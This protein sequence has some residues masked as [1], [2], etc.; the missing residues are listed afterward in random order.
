[1]T[2]SRMHPQWIDTEF[3]FEDLDVYWTTKPPMIPG[4]EKMGIG[5]HFE[6]TKGTLTCDY[7][8]CTIRIGNE[9]MNDIPEIQRQLSGLRGIN[10][11]LLIP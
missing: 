11:I 3:K 10:V 2:V 8:A 4:A 7:T 1:M 9:V 6:G 5:A